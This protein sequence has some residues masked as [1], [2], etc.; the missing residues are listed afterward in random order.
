MLGVVED[1]YVVADRGDRVDEGGD[2]AVARAGELAALAVDETPTV[3]W[4]FS[5]AALEVCTE[6]S[7]SGASRSRYSERKIDQISSG[8]I[9]PP[10]V[11]VCCCT[12]RLNSIC[13]RLG[14][15]SLCSALRT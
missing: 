2:G 15:S 10:S 7:L 1:S 4:S 13:A 5:P 14:R 8:V 6:L 9:S 12:T 3:S 11:S